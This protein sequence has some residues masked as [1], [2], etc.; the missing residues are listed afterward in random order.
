MPLRAPLRKLALTL[1]VTASVG[2]LGAVGA[3][4]ALAVAGATRPEAEMVR[5]AY[6][7][8]GV[9][10]RCVIVPLG[11]A[12]LVTGL[13]SSL[14]TEWGLVRHYWVLVKLV[15]ALPL[16]LLLLVHTRP[17]DVIAGAAAERALSSADLRGLRTQLVAYAGAA[18]LAL[19]VATVLSIYKPRGRTPLGA[20]KPHSPSALSGAGSQETSDSRPA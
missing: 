6:L 14:A 19:L 2:W 17:V 7:A 5:G 3:F 9:T 1:H 13:V 8:M 15:M 20:R 4:L 10:Y 18:L 16:T 11:L 12:S